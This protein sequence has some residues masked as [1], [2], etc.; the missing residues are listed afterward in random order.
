MPK[1]ANPVAAQRTAAAPVEQPADDGLCDVLSG[2]E[3]SGELTE[4]LLA[5]APSLTGEQIVAV[6]RRFREIAV[7]HGWVDGD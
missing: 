6:R 7:A 4:A 2:A 3:F 5:A 1:A